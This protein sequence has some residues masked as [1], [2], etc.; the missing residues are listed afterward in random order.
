MN[1]EEQLQEYLER[2]FR[3]ANELESITS[4]LVEL[5]EQ[6]EIRFAEG[7]DAGFDEDDEPVEADARP[8]KPTM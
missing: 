6:A 3:V 2:L 7:Y 5:A 1:A 4:G 8:D